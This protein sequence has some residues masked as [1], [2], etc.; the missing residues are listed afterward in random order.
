[1]YTSRRIQEFIDTCKK[2]R[3]F[4]AIFSDL[5]GVWF[6]SEKYQ[7][8][9]KSPDSVSK[10]EFFQLVQ[11]AENVLK[12]YHVYFYANENDPKFHKLY[13]DLINELRDRGIKIEIFSDLQQIS[14]N[15]NDLEMN[16]QPTDGILFLSI[17][18][19]EKSI[20]GFLLNP[21]Y[22]LIFTS[23]PHQK[24]EILAKRTQI[25]QLLKE[26]QLFFDNSNL[27]IH[28]YNKELALGPD[29]GRTEEAYYLPAVWRY[30]GR[31]YQGLGISGKKG[32]LN[33]PHHFLIISG[34]YGLISP[35]DSIQLYSIPLYHKDPVQEIWK[36][37]DFLT[38][39]L[40]DYLKK[41]S[42][43]KIFDFTG[44]YYYRDLID[45]TKIK[46]IHVDAD[47]KIEVIH[48]FSARGAGEHSLTALGEVI[49]ET[50]IHMPEGELMGNF[51]ERSIK[52]VY[53]RN[54]HGSWP[55]NPSDNLPLGS[56][57][58]DLEKVSDEET[59]EILLSAEKATLN[60]CN[61]NQNPSDA[62]SSIIWQYGKGLEKLLHNAI[63]IKIGQYLSSKYGA[64]I[65]YQYFY[66]LPFTV[67]KWRNAT[68][69]IASKQ[70]T[71]G[72]WSRVMEDLQ[73]NK[74]N[75]IVQDTLDH[76]NR[77][78]KG[79]IMKISKICSEIEDIRN[80]ATHPKIISFEQG[81]Q[82]RNRIIPLINE[83][84]HL[85]YN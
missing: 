9:D 54:I 79:K 38:N 55:D 83:T 17:C 32:I 30:Q 34:L 12:K 33:S 18:S 64:R 43:K 80:N 20:E 52:N 61:N 50:L 77:E 59:K 45:W 51:V 14:H 23:F 68:N 63:S 41:Y 66:S 72:Q 78:F 49:G 67:K 31:F 15:P 81:L 21:S 70:L 47:T 58:L 29:F 56:A 60:S 85:I 48:C 76:M 11:S 3:A 53:F 57:V 28:P 10:S 8:Y 19:Y 13:R 1:M 44:L 84:I 36:K 6:P 35:V 62:G 2:V 4:W 25:L 82:W 27:K 37:K 39:L 46:G 40:I 24:N 65:P 69:P 5:Y 71:L 74:H 16:Y 22:P 26:D 73:S 42:I 7:Y 75:P